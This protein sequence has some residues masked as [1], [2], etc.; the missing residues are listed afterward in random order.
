MTAI[1]RPAFIDTNVLIDATDEARPQH[2]LAIRLLERHP[3]L[4]MSAQIARE[5]LVVCTRP[6]G[7]NGLGL[8]VEDAVQNLSALRGAVSL[9]PEEQPVLPT[10][11]TLLEH[12]PVAG[13]AI[14]D[15]A[16]VAALV[17]HRLSELITSNPGDFSRFAEIANIWPLEA[18]AGELDTEGP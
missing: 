6:A 13:K 16:V 5:Y 2:E 3:S 11:L 14:H 7:A 4:V 10:F 15:A 1:I 8:P 9:L 18:A 12:T 17:A